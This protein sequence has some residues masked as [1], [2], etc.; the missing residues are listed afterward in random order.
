MSRTSSMHE[1]GESNSGIIPT[2]QPNK[3][4]AG[5]GGEGRPLTK[6]NPLEINACRT[7]SRE[8]GRSGLEG[9]RNLPL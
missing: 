3:G 9:V 8:S 6:E 5:G 2:K 1:G 7:P 4:G